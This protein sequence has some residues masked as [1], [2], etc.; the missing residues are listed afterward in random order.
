MVDTFSILDVFPHSW[1]KLKLTTEEKSKKNWYIRKDYDKRPR[2]FQN[3]ITL[4]L[5]ATIESLDE[6]MLFCI[7]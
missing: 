4:K 5:I 3:V 7:R 6:V 2:K 1:E